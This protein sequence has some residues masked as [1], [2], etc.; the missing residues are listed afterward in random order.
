ML[1]ASQVPALRDPALA[2]QFLVPGRSAGA[3]WAPGGWAAHGQQLRP[4]L[5][6]LLPN[7]KQPPLQNIHNP[8]WPC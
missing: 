2:G 5:P 1:E 7:S 4:P 3:A 8:R 6:A